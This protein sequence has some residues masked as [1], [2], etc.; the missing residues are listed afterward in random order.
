[1]ISECSSGLD[2]EYDADIAPSTP[3]PSLYETIY[4]TTHKSAVKTVCFN[5]DGQFPF[6]PRK[7]DIFWQISHKVHQGRKR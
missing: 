2:L 5:G 1:M 7:S 6:F 3:E 4:L